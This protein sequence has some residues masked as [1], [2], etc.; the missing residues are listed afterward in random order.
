MSKASDVAYGRRGGRWA[1]DGGQAESALRAIHKARLDAL[2]KPTSPGDPPAWPDESVA[3]WRRLADQARDLRAKGAPLDD[4]LER[5]L[6][7]DRVAR[8]AGR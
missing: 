3:M 6:E 8:E 4:T 7:V 5:A 2:R 1:L